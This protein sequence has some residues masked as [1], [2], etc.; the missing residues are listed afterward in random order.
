[1]SKYN[2]TGFEMRPREQGEEASIARAIDAWRKA[3]LVGRVKYARKE[4]GFSAARDKS[5]PFA[6]SRRYA[7][8]MSGLHIG[9]D[10]P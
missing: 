9:E 10:R 5:D 4:A 3:P 7:H 1:M 8:I 6:Y 2:R